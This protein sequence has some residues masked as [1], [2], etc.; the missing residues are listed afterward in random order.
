[1][2]FIALCSNQNGASSFQDSCRCVWESRKKYHLKENA[3]RAAKRH[4]CW[5]RW[6]GWGYR[7]LEGARVISVHPNSY[8]IQRKKWGDKARRSK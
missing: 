1:M 4:K 2:A 5:V 3:E 8:G 7:S 6:E